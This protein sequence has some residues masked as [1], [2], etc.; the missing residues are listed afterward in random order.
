MGSVD[1][2]LNL[3]SRGEGTPAKPNAWRIPRFIFPTIFLSTSAPT[4]AQEVSRFLQKTSAWP[5]FKLRPLEKSRSPG[6][7]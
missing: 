2:G 7:F 6:V 5:G 3:A 1:N 4:L